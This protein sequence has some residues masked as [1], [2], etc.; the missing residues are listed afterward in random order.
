MP[1]PQQQGFQPAP[2]YQSAPVYQ[3]VPPFYAPPAYGQ[4]GVF[5]Q[6][7]PT[8]P[9]F[10]ATVAASAPPAAAAKNKR[11]KKNV[12]PAVPPGV[13]QQVPF[14]QNQVPFMT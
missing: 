12:V 7:V 14:A 2:G 1:F 11:K 13:S 5:Y 8:A 6:Q 10:Q 9:S 3:Q 4:V